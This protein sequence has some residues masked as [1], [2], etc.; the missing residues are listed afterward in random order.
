MTRYLRHILLLIC[1][2]AGATSA[3]Y[4]Q[5]DAQLTQY[6]EVPSYYNSA[7]LG[8]SDL[9][10]IRGGMR[11]QWIGIHGAPRSFAATAEMPVKLLGKRLGVGLVTQQEGIG[12]YSN[13]GLSAQ[14][15]YQQPLFKG[16]LSIGVGLGFID[17]SFKGSEVNLPDDDDYHQGSDD[18]IPMN[19]IRGTAFDVSLGLF[20]T[21]KLFWAGLSVN[22]LNSPV[23]TLDSESGEGGNEDNYEFQVGRTAYFMAGSNIAIK[24][25][26]LEVIPSVM[27][28]TDFQF[29]TGEVTARLRYNKF[30]SAGLGYRWKDALMVI[31]GAEFKGFF[32]GYSYDYPTS[33][34]IKG[35]SGSHEVFAGYSLKLD[36]SEKNKNKH[37]SIRIM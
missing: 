36:F 35:S 31:L 6:Y 13:F 26:L 7:A 10:R 1:A 28:K 3:V 27:V 17:Q 32:I 37:K 12:L 23:I 24:N 18:A 9:L 19:D 33:A 4:A 22:H 15:A 16:R 20:Y 25:T 8:T 5:S 34:I 2:L 14:A 21:H 30:L 29:T 11:M